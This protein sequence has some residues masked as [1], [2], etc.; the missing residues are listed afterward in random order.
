MFYT[1]D[2]EEWLTWVSESQYVHCRHSTMHA[3]ANYFWIVMAYWGFKWSSFEVEGFFN[4]LFFY[5]KICFTHWILRSDWHECLSHSICLLQTEYNAC[6][7]KLLLD[8]NGLLFTW[9]G[10]KWSSFEEVEG[11]FNFLF[12]YYKICFTHWFLGFWGVT[13]MS[14]WCMS[15][16]CMQCMQLQIIVG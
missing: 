4:H 3:V 2:S 1:L 5:Y 7:Y 11:F 16:W 9:W 13:D 14:V 6:S 8:S 15:V 10:F 12:F